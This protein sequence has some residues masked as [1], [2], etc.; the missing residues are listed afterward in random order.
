LDII[1]AN[2]TTVSNPELG[3]KLRSIANS[4]DTASCK[5]LRNELLVGYFEKEKL[6]FAGKVH[7][8]LNPA[9]RAALLKIL[10]PLRCDKCLFANLPTEKRG[11]FGEGVTTEEMTDYIWLQPQ[12]VADIG[13]AEWTTGGVLRHAE[14]VGLREDKLPREA[15]G[16]FA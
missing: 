10:Q 9:N 3:R 5:K 4:C 16:S 2:T 7:Q 8:G 15:L 12:V 13:F 1:S 11:H 6:L 14:F